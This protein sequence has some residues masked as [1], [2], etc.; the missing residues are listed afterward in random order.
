[1]LNAL[2][3]VLKVKNKDITTTSTNTVLMSLFLT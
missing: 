1:M 3:D 2:F